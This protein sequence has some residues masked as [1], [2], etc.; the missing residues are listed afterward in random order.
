MY[1]LVQTKGAIE[2][3]KFVKESYFQ[4]EN[5]FCQEIINNLVFK[6][7]LL[8]DKKSIVSIIPSSKIPLFVHVRRSDYLSW[9]SKDNPAVLPASY[10][11]KC[12]EL[13]RS[14]ISNPFFIFTSDDPFYVEDIFGDVD[15]SYIS[16]SSSIEDFVLMS[17]CHGG[18]LSASS[19]SWWAAYFSNLRNIDS[20]FLA[21]NHWGGHRLRSWYPPHVKSSFL[22]YVDV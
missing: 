7:T 2:S 1:D 12:I 8:A 21:P 11:K 22:Q 3:L 18:I 9:P 13:I 14:K 6:N 20:T 15:S 10:Y 19:F 17:H 16:R 5:L 4:N